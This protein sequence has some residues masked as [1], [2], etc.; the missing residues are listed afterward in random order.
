[1]LICF[2]CPTDTVKILIYLE[3]P[4]LQTKQLHSLPLVHL[5]SAFAQICLSQLVAD[6]CGACISAYCSPLTAACALRVPIG[7]D[8]TPDEF[9]CVSGATC[10]SG[11]CTATVPPSGVARMRRNI[12]RRSNLCPDSQTACSI[13]GSTGFECIDTMVR[14][15]TSLLQRNLNWSFDPLLADQSWAMWILRDKRRCRLHDVIW[16][17][18]RRMRVG[19]L[20]NLGLCG[21]IRIW[22]HLQRLSYSFIS[23]RYRQSL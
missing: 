6:L 5:V 1:M 7:G 15:Y 12:E 14:C 16:S 18:C 3:I 23:V 4:I 11:I 10:V 13:A 19:N 8:C 2:V 21:W 9:S 20:R 22:R 17:R